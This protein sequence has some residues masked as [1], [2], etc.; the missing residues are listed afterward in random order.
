MHRL[1]SIEAWRIISS[2][3]PYLGRCDM[4]LLTFT[5]LALLAKITLPPPQLSHYCYILAAALSR[6]TFHYLD[7][8]F[9]RLRLWY[10]VAGIVRTRSTVYHPYW[11]WLE[12]IGKLELT[13][14]VGDF[15]SASYVPEL[16]VGF[17]QTPF[18]IVL[19]ELHVEVHMIEVLL[20]Q[21]WN[22]RGVPLI[23]L[24]E[25]P[26]QTFFWQFTRDGFLIE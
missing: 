13:R 7:T 5:Q 12:S 4:I 19:E 23:P 17:G 9:F 26:F 2:C 21:L 1:K 16:S 3:L 14:R 15:V 22:P 8:L 18:L 20:L 11:L 24:L 10:F 25:F 6:L